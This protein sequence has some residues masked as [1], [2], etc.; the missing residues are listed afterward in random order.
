[1]IEQS[2]PTSP[3]PLAFFDPESSSWRTSQGCLL[4]AAPESLERLPAW[5]MW[6]GQV[7][8]RLKKPERRISDAD[9]SVLP[10]P[11][12]PGGGGKRRGGNRSEELLL[13][14]VA[15]QLARL[16]PTPTTVD[17]H[18]TGR[19]TERLVGGDTKDLALREAVKMLPTQ[20]ANNWVDC[21]D[22]GHPTH[23]IAHLEA[24]FVDKLLPTPTSVDSKVFGP[25][26]DW[27]LRLL[28]HAPHTASVLMGLPLN[29]GGESSDDPPPTQQT[30]EGCGPS[31]SPG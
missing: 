7:L 14:G 21:D 2:S 27:Q 11:V 29:D 26:V 17:S 24:C 9:G 23:S 20:T 15:E 18:S 30:I 31:S 25:N 3:T 13:P 12:V 10:T 16:L 22:C 6:D 4:S 5:V 8:Y 19:T 1:M 28:N